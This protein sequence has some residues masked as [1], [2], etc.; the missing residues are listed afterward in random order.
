MTH[1]SGLIIKEIPECDEY[2]KLSRIN[3]YPTQGFVGGVMTDVNEFPHMSAI[4]ITEVDTIS[5]SCGASLIS[6][7]FVVTAAHCAPKG[8]KVNS[9]VVR[10]G[11]KNL[12]RDDDGAKPQSFGVKKVIVHPE[13]KTGIKYHD[14]ALMQ[15][16]T[17][18]M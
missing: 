14:I 4:G 6:E 7:D 13:Y 5:W 3:P 8:D 9:L 10:V 12:Q 2:S 15:L 18:A 1:N 16:N 11:D 17:S